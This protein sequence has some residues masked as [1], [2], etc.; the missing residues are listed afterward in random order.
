MRPWVLALIEVEVL[1]VQR[2]VSV[3]QEDGRVGFVY[4]VRHYLIGT[5]HWVSFMVLGS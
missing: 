3:T 2:L 5:I 4:H 1:E